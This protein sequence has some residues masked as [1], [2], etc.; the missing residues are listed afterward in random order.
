[1]PFTPGAKEHAIIHYQSDPQRSILLMGRS[2]TGKTTC[3]VFRM[4]AQ[5]TEYIDGQHGARPRQLFVTKNDVLC[6]EVKRSFSNMGLAWRRRNDPNASTLTEVRTEEERPKFLTSSEW[7]DNLDIELPGSSFFTKAELKQR[8]DNRKNRDS[9]TKGIEAML[10]EEIVDNSTASSI[11][12]EMT[13]SVFRKLWR[14][15][16]SGSG[17][18]M[19]CTMVWREIKSFIKGSVAALQ[20]D[21]KDRSLHQNRFLS[22]DEYLALP[23]KQSRMDEAQR[24]EVYEL[25]QIYEKLKKEGCYYDEC[26]LVYNI[27]GRITSLDR[28]ILEK[29]SM[30]PIDS[31]FV[32]EVQDFTQAELYILAK[33]CRDPNNL[34]LA[35]DTAQSIAVGVDFRF[36]DVRQIFYNSFGGIEPQLLQ[37]SHNYRSHAGVLRLAAC[38]VELLYHFF[39]NS[40]DKLPPDLGLFSGPK[41]VI[42]DV[43]STQELV[44]MLQGAKRASRIEFGAHQVVIVRSEEAK[45]SLPDEFGIDPDWVMTVQESKGLEF[46]DVLLYN[47]FSDSPAE[48]LWRVVSSY[49]EEDIAAYYADATVSASGVQKYDWESPLLTETRHLEFE[50]DQHKLLE[51]ELKMLYTAITRARVNIFIAETDI[52]SSR[53]MFNYFQRRAVVDVVSKGNSEEEGLSGV[54]VFGAMNTVEDWRNRGEYYLRNAEGER[55]IGCLR[56]AAKCFDKAGEPKRRDYALAFLSFTEIEEQ[57]PAKLRGKHGVDLK[58]K[59]YNITEQLLEARDVGFLNKAA[60]CLLRTGEQEEYTAQL[61]ELYA[62]LCYTQR[63]CDEKENAT[64]PLAPSVHEKKYFSYAAKLF[65]KCAQQRGVK[66]DLA[67]SAFRN[68]VC[69]GMYDAAAELVDAGALPIE[70]KE[71]FYQL[72]QLCVTASPMDPTASFRKDFKQRAEKCSCV[73][74]AVKQVMSQL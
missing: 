24:R 16:R 32:D 15:I 17:S 45:K 65:A 58:Q 33:L 72:Y 49:S 27:A 46:D 64:L 12:H 36:T 54:R 29:T 52:E 66:F 68:Y 61:F 60:L 37:L 63:I 40:L 10:S 23:R 56:L 4:W 74:N 30:L 57:D 51:T 70:D 20:V 21:C 39:G 14:K 44:L 1:L 69:A 43:A 62:R 13:F 8:F 73:I 41:P 67:L 7:L 5:Y 42:M 35:G 34:F 3:L 47:F 6:R 11:R 50:A 31:L 28:C 22:L 9:V 26:D 18:Q 25:F 71:S 48:D 2:G 38:V 59:L 53:P 19:D 55:Q